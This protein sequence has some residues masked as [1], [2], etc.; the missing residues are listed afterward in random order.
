MNMFRWCLQWIL[1]GFSSNWFGAVYCLIRFVCDGR[2]TVQSE[3]ERVRG[4]GLCVVRLRSDFF[5]ST[6]NSIILR[7]HHCHRHCHPLTV[8]YIF[9]FHWFYASVTPK[10]DTK[11]GYFALSISDPA[12]I[13]VTDIP[14]T[15]ILSRVTWL[16]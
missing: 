2:Y 5:F 15:L 13:F 11:Q 9:Y 4:E 12:I 6:S 10:W 1:I 7:Q 16:M 14:Q 8:S 3:V